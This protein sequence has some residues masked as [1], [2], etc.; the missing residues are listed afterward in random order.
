MP[1][2]LYNRRQFHRIDFEGLANLDFIHGSYQCCSIKNLSLTGMCVEGNFS[3]KDLTNCFVTIFHNE[4][5]ADNSLQA[6]AK[7]VW[8]NDQGVGLKFTNM[9]LENY[10]L[11]QSTLAKKADQ[12]VVIL[13]E[14]PY[15][16]PF[17]V[18]YNV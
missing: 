10:E 18:N 3:K 9:S 5:S 15:S 6:A 11:L 1:M 14:V 13:R 2:K 7:V 12:P 8:R 16:Y 17:E 4:K